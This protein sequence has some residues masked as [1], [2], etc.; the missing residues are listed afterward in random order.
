MYTQVNVQI[1]K[2][3]LYLGID[4]PVAEKNVQLIHFPII[5]TIPRSFVESKK[6]FEQFLKYT[7]IIFTS[8]TSVKIYFQILSNLAFPKKDIQTKQYITVGKATANALN[9]HGIHN[10][11]I[12]EN[13]TAEGIVELLK[14][15]NL[16]NPHFFWPHSALSRN[17]LPQYFE[18]NHLK[19]THCILYDTIANLP[20]TLPDLSQI[21]EIIFTSPSTVDAFLQFFKNP[22][23]HNILTP[24]GPITK[25][26]LENKFCIN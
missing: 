6:P 21:D 3:V 26:K 1:M 13:E 2:R 20:Q 25:S 19:Y 10:I 24:I 17:T 14:N 5:K 15:L 11:K 4:K 18:Y 7:H 12:A 8:K 9:Q 16:R 23:P 22:Q